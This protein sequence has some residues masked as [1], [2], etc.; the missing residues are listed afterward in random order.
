MRTPAD[1]DTLTDIP[2]FG[3]ER[4]SVEDSGGASSIGLIRSENEDSFG[5]ID[6]FYVVADGMGG[7]DGGAMASKLTVERS[8]AAYG[9]EGWVSALAELNDHV[10]IECDAAGYPSAGSTLAGLVVEDHRCVT[11]A[12]GD[13]R[14]YRYRE[15][16]LRQLT[17][18]HNLRTLRREEGLAPDVTDERGK[19]RALTSF[20][21]NSDSSQRIDVGTVSVQKGDRLLLTSDGV[22]EQVDEDVIAQLMELAT[23]QETADALVAA[24]DEAGGRDNAT[25]IVVS[26]TTE[27][28]EGADSV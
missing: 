3:N 1:D 5:S 4:L 9:S 13:S 8:L 27:M 24:A 12:M 20:V 19:P 18:D 14:I 15:G 16:E 10:R 17:T 28:V 21:G 26:V 7:T 23:C 6:R 2:D 22:H 25:A 11:L